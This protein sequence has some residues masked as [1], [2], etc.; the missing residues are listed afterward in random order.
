MQ[1]TLTPNTAVTLTFPASAIMLTIVHRQ[2]AGKAARMD[3]RNRCIP[4]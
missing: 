4:Y 3:N 2:Q 1:E